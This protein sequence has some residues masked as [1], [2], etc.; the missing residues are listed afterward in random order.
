MT[1]HT[2]S[3]TVEQLAEAGDVVMLSL[4]DRTGGLSSR[5][6]TIAEVA[7]AHLR[8]LVDRSAAWVKAVEVD[9]LV[10]VSLVASGRNVWASFSG[11]AGFNRDH[12]EIERLWSKPAGAYFEG[13]EDPNITVLDVRVGD[14]EYWSAPGG[15]PIGRLASLVG[16]ALGKGDVVNDHGPVTT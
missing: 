11:D 7:G 14:G 4:R 2:E 5:P 1:D 8:F 9:R 3:K 16:A 15:G 6:L 12:A 10:N 13:S